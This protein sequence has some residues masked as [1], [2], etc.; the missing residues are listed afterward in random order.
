MGATV[1]GAP[2]LLLY[3]VFNDLSIEK[4]KIVCFGAI[5]GFFVDKPQTVWY[6]SNGRDARRGYRIKIRYRVH[7]TDST[8]TVAVAPSFM[9][10]DF[11]APS[12]FSEEGVVLMHLVTRGYL[13]IAFCVL[14][15]TYRVCGSVDQP[16][17]MTKKKTA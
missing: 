12:K 6:N 4:N 14:Y 13:R 7:V 3:T 11:F 15:A 9:E 5:R 10:G 2:L 1:I 16:Q 17:I 8:I